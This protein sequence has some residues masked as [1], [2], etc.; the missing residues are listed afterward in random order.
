MKVIRTARKCADL[1]SRSTITHTASCFRTIVEY[2]KAQQ[3][4][5]IL[6]PSSHILLTFCIRIGTFDRSRV[7]GL[8]QVFRVSCIIVTRFVSRERIWI[9]GDD[10]NRCGEVLGSEMMLG[11]KCKG[12]GTDKRQTG[13]GTLKQEIN[14]GQV[15]PVPLS[16]VPVPPSK[17]SLEAKWYWYH[18]NRYR[19]QHV[20]FV[21]FEQNSN[22]SARVRSY[23]D[24]KSE[25]TMEKG[26]K[27]KGKVES[28][29]FGMLGFWF[30]KRECFSHSF[31]RVHRL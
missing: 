3:L 12:S 5:R 30:H 25:I 2:T 1:V 19:Y 24:H 29:V 17:K 8:V 18:T 28:G 27:A 4:Y 14:S 7:F 15:V 10:G 16:P 13:T 22:S 11:N 26:I 20:I 23:F 31:V 6:I 21:G 9:I